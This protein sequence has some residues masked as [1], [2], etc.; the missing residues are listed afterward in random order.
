MKPL[1]VC[2]NED[3]RI[4]QQELTFTGQMIDIMLHSETNIDNPLLKS[5]ETNAFAVR[6]LLQVPLEL[7]SR[8]DR[9]RIRQ[10]WLQAPTTHSNKSKKKAVPERDG[11]N[12]QNPLYKL[13]A[14]SPEVLSLKVNVMQLPTSYEVRTA[15]DVRH[16]SNADDIQGMKFEDLIYLADA[17]AG[18]K[19]ADLDLRVNLAEFKKLAEL[20]LM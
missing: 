1:S 2:Q 18:A 20:T 12:S 3:P 14:L 8:K 13:T 7:F 9:T 11:H 15:H 16:F 5:A 6:S 4:S 17:L 19:T 10:G